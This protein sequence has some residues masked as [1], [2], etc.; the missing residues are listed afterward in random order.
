MNN[1]NN[2][3]IIILYVNRLW[4]MNSN[5]NRVPRYKYWQQYVRG[6]IGPWLAMRH[7]MLPISLQVRHVVYLYVFYKD[8]FTRIA[9]QWVLLAQQRIFY[10]KLI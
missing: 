7:R 5:L 10:L 3:K 2:R 4:I 8:K 9:S 1:I 6:N